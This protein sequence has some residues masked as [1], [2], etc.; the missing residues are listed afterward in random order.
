MLETDRHKLGEAWADNYVFQ[1]SLFEGLVSVTEN[2]DHIHVL[3]FGAGKRAEFVPIYLQIKPG[4][5]SIVAYDPVVNPDY[6]IIIADYPVIY[7]RRFPENHSFDLVILHFSLHHI[8][9]AGMGNFRKII[10]Q[11]GSKFIAVADYDF[12]EDLPMDQFRH[13]F[14]ANTEI[15]EINT[16]FSGDWQKA[17][18]ELSRCHRSD[19]LDAMKNEGY[20][21]VREGRGEEHATYKYFLIGV[22]TF[23]YSCPDK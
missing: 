4:Q 20:T 16:H 21:V 19:C 22:K 5:T 23:S 11:L 7:T 17:K 13:A 12:P 3:D 10:R 1:H 6:R 15:E 14:S 8:D 2:L 9:D 18:S